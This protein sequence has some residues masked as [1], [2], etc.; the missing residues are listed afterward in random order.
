MT[1]DV[2]SADYDVVRRPIHDGLTA[3][4]IRRALGA[5]MGAASIVFGALALPTAIQQ[6]SLLRP[7]WSALF[8]GLLLLLPVV[9][10][11]GALIDSLRVM[12]AAAWALTIALPVATITWIPAMVDPPLIPDDGQPWLLAITAV[13][14]SAAC[15]VLSRRWAWTYVL[16]A[17]LLTGG[18][19]V[20][21][22]DGENHFVLAIGDTLYMILLC[23]I[24]AAAIL[25]VLRAATTLDRSI[26]RATR[27]AAAIAD[28]RAL[29]RE[30]ARFD[31]L[32]HDEILSTLVGVLR[33]PTASDELLAQARRALMRVE[34]LD[35]S[36][37]PVSH[38]GE[39]F[40]ERLSRTIA[41]ISPRPLFTSSVT[42][43]TSMPRSVCAALSDATAEAVRNALR[44][45]APD[46]VIA[47]DARVE[48]NQVAVTVRDEGP[49]FA[50]D[51]VDDSRLG[52][53]L[54]IIARMRDVPG[55]SAAISSRPGAGTSVGLHWRR[56]D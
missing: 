28:A 45:T 8:I 53:R 30:N 21:T 42:H 51:D 5:S 27:E 36:A 43:G 2:P 1:V 16:A 29:A 15:F 34:Q 24:F 12:R 32:V 50:H 7:L 38:P 49:G 22:S 40:A 26:A 41:D 48:P 20:I 18:L 11:V 47:V 54:S 23:S 17:S 4:G 46:D 35:N 10:A 33:Q 37:E 9:V 52:V 19:R 3:R 56:D 14:T 39:H 31:A 55:G 6:I 25:A 13:P 44:H